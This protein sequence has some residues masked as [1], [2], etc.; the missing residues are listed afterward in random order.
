VLRSFTV[1]IFGAKSSC[2]NYFVVMIL[3]SAL[4]RN[5]LYNRGVVKMISKPWATVRLQERLCSLSSFKNI[6]PG[7]VEVYCYIL[8]ENKRRS[9]LRNLDFKFQGY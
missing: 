7:A 3:P 5:I 1:N 6:N 8:C 9:S 2:V 4:I